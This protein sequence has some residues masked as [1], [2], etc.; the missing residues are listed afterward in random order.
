MLLNNHYFKHALD[1]MLACKSIKTI[2]IH[3]RVPIVLPSRIESN[4]LSLMDDYPWKKVMVVHTNHPQELNEPVQQ[5]MKHLGSHDWTLLN[6]SVLLSG[7]NDKVEILKEFD[8]IA[9]GIAFTVQTV[10]RR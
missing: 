3:S 5:A 9:P 8:S 6:Q 10:K 4:W 7:V 1:A 2:R